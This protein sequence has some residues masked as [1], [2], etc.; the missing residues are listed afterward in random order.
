VITGKTALYGIL[1][2]PVGHSR[3][4][5]MQTAAFA[6][7]GLDAVYV[8]LP[9]SPERLR[10]GVQGAHALGFHGLNVTVPHKEGVVP[11]CEGVDAV[12]KEF[13]AVNTLRRTPH[14][15]EGFNTDAPACL[16]LLE[17]A[18][19]GHGARALL[20]GSGGAARA[21]AWALA[22]LGATV[23][24]A[25]RRLEKARE[26]ADAVAHRAAAG[27]P[28]PS[29][30]GW[31]DLEPECRAADVVVNATSIGLPGRQP[32]EIPGLSLRREQVA[33]DFVY[34]DTAFVREARAAGARVVTGEQI[35]VRQ[36]ALAFTLWTGRPAPEAVMTAAVHRAP[37]K[38]P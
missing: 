12:A 5:V 13:G 26:V 36:G 29:A 33:L 2:H 10:E 1:G 38:T 23:R 18:G 24:V 16:A 34:G 19:V 30:I 8:P 22:R 25:A 31:D 28:V 15:W 17:A 27:V 37:E 32:A 35:L 20:V 11:L 21:G 6:E 7:L 14:G 3:S 4:P 9:V